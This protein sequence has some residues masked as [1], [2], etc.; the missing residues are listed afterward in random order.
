M[1]IK[2]LN[3]FNFEIKFRYTLLACIYLSFS[4]RGYNMSIENNEANMPSDAEI[5]QILLDN[6][7]KLKTQS[8]GSERLNDYVLPAIKLVVLKALDNA[9]KNGEQ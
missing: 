2:L 6:G 4:K 7:F 3:Y 8:D 1:L 9:K 5:T